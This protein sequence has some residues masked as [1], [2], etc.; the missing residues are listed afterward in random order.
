LQDTEL[1]GD[2]KKLQKLSLTGN[3]LRD[4]LSFTISKRFKRLTSQSPTSRF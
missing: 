4:Q 1:A 3:G 2:I